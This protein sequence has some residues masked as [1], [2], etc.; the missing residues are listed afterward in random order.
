M[1]FHIAWHEGLRTASGRCELSVVARQLSM[2]LFWLL[3]YNQQGPG[4]IQRYDQQLRNALH[5]PGMRNL[6]SAHLHLHLHLH[7]PCKGNNTPTPPT[8]HLETG[9]TNLPREI[10]L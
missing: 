6:H 1:S 7:L 5:L 3:V 2:S 4:E 9:Q 8:P 10:A